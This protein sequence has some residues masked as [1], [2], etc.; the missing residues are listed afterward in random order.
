MTNTNSTPQKPPV[1][2]EY[3]LLKDIMHSNATMKNIDL[4][5]LEWIDIL[6]H[7]SETAAKNQTIYGVAYITRADYGGKE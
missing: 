1:S 3:A 4:T 5:A 2:C 7:Q 6:V